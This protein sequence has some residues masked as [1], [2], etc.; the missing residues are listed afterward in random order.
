VNGLS[1]S[2]DTE[3]LASASS[4]NTV[5]LWDAPERKLK[6]TLKPNAAELR[7]VA[8]SGNGK[9]LAAGTRYGK[10]QVWDA[11]GM[12]EIA[13]LSGHAGDVWAVAFDY[14]GKTLASGDGDWNRPG[15][16][17]LWD[18]ETWKER[19]SLQTSGEVLSLAFAPK[20]RLLAA[21][22]WDMTVKVWD[23]AEPIEL[24]MPRIAR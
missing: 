22:C 6:A 4:D 23:S 11:I 24:P 1:F 13:T 5:K 8:F 15:S 19:K 9:F 12:N 17:R 20:S 18:T 16:V 10:V 3:T 2:P 14:D 21:G 7:S